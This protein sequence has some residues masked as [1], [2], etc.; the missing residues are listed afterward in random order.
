[1]YLLFIR[2]GQSGNNALTEQG[3]SQLEREPDPH[4]TEK[5]REQAQ[6]IGQW[7]CKQNFRPTKLY[8]SLMIRAIET[9]TPIADALNLP[10]E[11]RDDLFEQFG[12]YQGQWQDDCPYAGAS[13]T[14]LQALSDKLVLPAAA[15]EAGWRFA[16]HLE[17]PI[18]TTQRAQKV[19][20][21]LRGFSANEVVA[22]VSHGVFG[23]FLINVL[24]A[25]QDTQDLYEQLPGKRNRS[26]ALDNTSTTIVQLDKCTHRVWWVNRVDHLLQ[27][28]NSSLWINEISEQFNGQP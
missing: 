27:S 15:T 11:A 21:W 20:Q 8:T 7:L 22:V 18:E 23:S 10:L 24:T 19:L 12:P 3:K 25:P 14:K 13:R 1:M 16:K 17:T 28:E 5:G 4:L 9:A 26:F 6:A 2:H